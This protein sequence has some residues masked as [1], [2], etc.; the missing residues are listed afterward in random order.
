MPRYI[1]I[2]FGAFIFMTI[3]CQ[4]N[5]SAPTFDTNTSETSSDGGADVISP[6]DGTITDAAPECDKDC[7]NRVCGPDPV[8]GL[9][10]GTCSKG[11]CTSIGQCAQQACKPVS[12]MTLE[13]TEIVGMGSSIAVNDQ[14]SVFISYYDNTNSDLKLATNASGK[15]VLSTLDDDEF[16]GVTSSLGIDGNGKLHIA[17]YD[18]DNRDLKYA[19]NAS[20]TWNLSVLDS[21]G[22]VGLY[23]SLGI[24]VNGTIY[25]AYPSDTNLKL[26]TYEAGSWI[27]S[28]LATN[29]GPSSSSLATTVKG[30]AYVS[31]YD[32]KDKVLKLAT[33]VT[34][35]WSKSIPNKALTEIS[36]TSLKIDDAGKLYLAYAYHG[37]QY[38]E[39]KLATNVS[40]PWKFSTINSSGSLGSY[41]PLGMDAFGNLYVAYYDRSKG[42]VKFATNGSGKWVISTVD[43]GG[44]VGVT[45]SLAVEPSGKAHISY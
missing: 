12:A 27:I 40:G 45:L 43:S 2:L 3:G 10:C 41:S 15:W 25:V 19:T 24:G 32:N 28:S 17:Y 16:V 35:I 11:N 44:D 5:G 13:N 39:L 42:D 31:Y 4:G 29:V 37:G 8:C 21:D 14:G 30:K 38:P 7:T 9:S 23:P 18:Y 34:G 1:W 22:E 6:N 36:Y 33:N 26:A 20:G